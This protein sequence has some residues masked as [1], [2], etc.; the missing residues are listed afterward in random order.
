[1]APT[2]T[3]NRK[4]L[5]VTLLT[6][7]IVLLLLVGAVAA[8]FLFWKED[9]DRR[10]VLQTKELAP[11]A[12]LPLTEATEAEVRGETTVFPLMLRCSW[13][14]EDGRVWTDDGW[15]RTLIVYG[16]MALAVGGIY[17]SV[18]SKRKIGG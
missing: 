2:S 13:P 3:G 1:M 8:P 10:C 6:V 14:V 4:L 16:G 12:A 7:S 18:R 11:P 15:S 9:P 5:R 17:A